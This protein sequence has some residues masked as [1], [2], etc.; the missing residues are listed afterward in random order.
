MISS[1]KKR[2]VVGPNGK[3]EIQSSELPQG[4]SVEVIVLL[5]PE[6]DETEYLLSSEA[7][8]NHLIEA[9]ENIEKR[10]NLISFTPDEWDEKYN[11]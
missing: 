4:A 2:T 1:I 6:K 10:K 8:K 9:I 11:V 7:N 3:I 5:D